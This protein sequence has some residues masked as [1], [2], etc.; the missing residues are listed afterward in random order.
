MWW[1]AYNEA[2][3][4][5]K[6]QLISDALFRA[7]FNLMCI[8]SANDGNL[9]ALK[10]LAFMLRLAPSRVA[11][12]LAQLHAAGLL[13]KTETGFVP[14]NWKGRQYKSDASTERVR[15]FRKRF[16]SVSGNGSVTPP[17]TEADTETER[18][19]E[20]RARGALPSADFETFW[21]AWPNKV[22][23]P[24]AIK[25]FSAAQKRGSAL[26]PILSGIQRYIV[27]KPPDR[28]W[29]NPSTF[30]NQNR[31]EDQPAQVEHGTTQNRIGVVAVAKRWAEHF[32]SQSG[33]GFEGN[34]VPVLRLPK[35]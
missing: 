33:D 8:A 21:N 14:H 24:A 10:D 1:R 13:D 34:S 16:K 28:P 7:W 27:D 22:G 23:K 29:L 15:R 30:L 2:I 6:L 4:D 26:K 31:W 11:L 18:K 25:A 3:N 32:E 5:P 17:E 19:K 12:M 20:T 35:G 9:P